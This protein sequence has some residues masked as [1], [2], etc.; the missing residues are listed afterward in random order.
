LARLVP[1]DGDHWWC[2][3]QLW[4]QIKSSLLDTMLAPFPPVRPR[5][6]FTRA[7]VN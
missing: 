7:A 2:A 5:M 1:G 6:R 4:Q 3:M